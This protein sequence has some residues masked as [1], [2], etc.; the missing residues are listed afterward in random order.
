MVHCFVT[1][2]LGAVLVCGGQASTLAADLTVYGQ[3][4][5]GAFGIESVEHVEACSKLG[6]TLLFTYSVARGKQFLDVNDP[7]GK[8]VRDRKM[9][10]MYNLSSRFTNVRLAREVAPGDTTIAV[11]PERPADI[12]AFPPSGT[13]AIEG[14]RITYAGHTRDA[15]TSCRRGIEGTK[16]VRHGAELILC[17]SETL[18][19]DILAEKDSPNLWGYWMVDDARL[20]EEDC[21]K[22]MAR[23]IRRYDRKVNGA[24]YHHVIVMGICGPR[25]MPNFSKGICDAI[26]VYLYPYYQGKLNGTV[27]GALP[28]ILQR[29]RSQQPDI[30]VIGVPQAFVCDELRWSVMPTP[31]QIREDIMAYLA[32]GAVGQVAYMY[33]STGPKGEPWGF[34]SSPGAC[35]AIGRAYREIRAGTLSLPMRSWTNS[36]EAAPMRRAMTPVGSMRGL[37]PN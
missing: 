10:V 33:H 13:L 35:E 12:D 17:N 15:F 6:M 3:P 29:A 26:G 21:L 2:A 1:A 19:Q 25:A 18:K 36:G 7:M 27:R 16:A 30:G 28:D 20:F 24:P 8:A 4:P 5:L 34:D 11:I 22:E 23:V 32:G 37:R 9:Q 14:E 31:E